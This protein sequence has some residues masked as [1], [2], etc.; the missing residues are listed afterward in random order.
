MADEAQDILRP[1]GSTGNE[2]TLPQR[3]TAATRSDQ[4]T[5]E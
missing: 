4:G 2:L 1:A 3:P 5:P